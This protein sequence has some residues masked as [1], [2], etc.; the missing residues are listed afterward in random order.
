MWTLRSTPLPS[1]ERVGDIFVIA[2]IMASVQAVDLE[3][4]LPGR[5]LD[6][7]R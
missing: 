2:E 5:G 4:E 1:D 6:S 7:P 3:G